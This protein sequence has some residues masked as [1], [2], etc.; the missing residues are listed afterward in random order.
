MRYAE[1]TLIINSE[2][3]EK[4]QYSN[5]DYITTVSEA[6]RATV[7]VVIIGEFGFCREKYLEV[8]QDVFQLLAPPGG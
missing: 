8:A 4:Q 5:T 7:G 3:L 2:L 1:F 6:S